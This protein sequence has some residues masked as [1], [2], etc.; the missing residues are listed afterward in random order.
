[1]RYCTQASFD[2]PAQPAYSLMMQ[3]KSTDNSIP[4]AIRQDIAAMPAYHVQDAAGMIKLDA[5]ENPFSLPANV[6][7][8]IAQAVSHAALNRYPPAG[9]GALVA[10]LKAALNIPNNLDVML[11]NGSDELLHLVIQATAAQNACVLA[12]TPGFVMYAMSATFNRVGFVGVPLLPNFELDLAA[13]LAA[14]SAHQPKV[15]F[16]AYPNNPTGNA[17]AV[18]DIQTIIAATAAVGGL[19]VIDEAYQPFADDT[20]LPR[21]AAMPHVLQNV[22]LVRTLSKLGL[23]GIRLG[24]AV[25]SPAIIEQL[26]KVRPPYNVNILTDAAATV[27]LGHLDVLNTQAAELRKQRARLMQ[28]LLGITGVV[29]YPSQANFILARVPNA[30]TWFEALKA[31]GILVKNVSNM[32]PLLANCLRLTVGSEAENS[33]LIEGL[34]TISALKTPAQ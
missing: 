33:A 22:L 16:I 19:V 12:P 26:N 24:Y 27:V 28:A 1:M 7:A 29:A 32:N 3:I 10:T 34:K 23:A 31:Q 4:N 5:M 13:M 21:I 15:V 18:A 8:E 2:I 17:W 14:I 30:A 25:G 9:N 6:L 20:W 11:G